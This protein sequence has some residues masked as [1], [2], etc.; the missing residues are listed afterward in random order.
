[1]HRQLLPALL[2]G[3]VLALC[4][5]SLRT[6]A[7]SAGE[8]LKP[9]PPD[10]K[11]AGMTLTEWAIAW[12]QWDN[13]LPITGSPDTDST[14]LQAAMGQRMPVWLLPG[15]FLESSYTRTVVIPAGYGI[16]LPGPSAVT[17]EPPGK[18]TDEQLAAKAKADAAGFLDRLRSY[19]VT[20]DGVPVP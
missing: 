14:G 6:G 7:W 16:V 12:S 11:V 4:T 13:S 3:T 2:R 5:L 10:E 8:P 9:L 17:F 19:D 20:I 15:W 18:L 1:M